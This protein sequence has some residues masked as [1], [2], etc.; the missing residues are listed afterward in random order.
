MASFV[1]FDTCN[2]KILPKNGEKHS[3]TYELC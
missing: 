1:T 2:P 3:E